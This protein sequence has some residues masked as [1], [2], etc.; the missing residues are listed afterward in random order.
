MLLDQV[1]NI[2]PLQSADHRP[3]LKYLY[4]ILLL[5]DIES[6]LLIDIHGI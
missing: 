1:Q 6:P 2:Y 4:E 5:R 3:G